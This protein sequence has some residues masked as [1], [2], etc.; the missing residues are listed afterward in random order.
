MKKGGVVLLGSLALFLGLGR[1]AAAVEVGI[2]FPWHEF[3]VTG[4][5]GTFATGC[6]PAD[7]AGPACTPSSAGNSEAVGA[8]PWTFSIPDI[9][10]DAFLTVTDAFDRNDRFDVFNFGALL[11]TTSLPGG[12][13]FCGSDPEPCLLDPAASHAVFP[14][15]AGDYSIT[16][17]SALTDPTLG[18]AAYFRVDAIVEDFP[19]PAPG[20]LLLLGAGLVGLAGLGWSRRRP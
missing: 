1:P 19:V 16:I 13:G 12:S 10:V 11:G 5:A 15:A 9:I 2:G 3:A 8:P 7:P 14:L 17:A 18:G 20:T 4:G 6:S